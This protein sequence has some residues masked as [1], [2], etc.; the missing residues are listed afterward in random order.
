MSSSPSVSSSLICLAI[1]SRLGGSA[2]TSVASWSAASAM[3]SAA[4]MNSG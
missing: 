2:A 4:W 3:I 1:A